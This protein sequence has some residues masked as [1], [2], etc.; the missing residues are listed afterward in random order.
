MNYK[1]PRKAI[2]TDAGFAS[3]YLPITKTIPKGMVP[4]GNKPVM[5]FVVEEC[6]KSGIEEVIIVATPEGKPIY[7]DYFTNKVP[8]I[9]AQL[10]KQGKMDRFEPVKE[11]FN[12]PK[13]TVIEQD[14]S[15]PYGNGSPFASAKSFIDDDEAFLAIYSDDLV[16]GT[17]AVKDLMDSFIKHPDA[18]AIIAGQIVPHE[19]I[20]KY[21]AID[22][23]P[24]T[25][26][27]NGLVEKPAPEEA[28]SDLAS[29]GRYL[30]TP[31]IF[32]FLDPSRTGKD[33]ELWTADAIAALIPTGRVYVKETTGKWVTTGDPKNYFLAHLEYVLKN[34]DYADDVRK[35]VAEN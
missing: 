17:P 29:Y 22:F 9:E 15:Y 3:R 18:V 27:L 14:P 4:M 20:K 25:E 30:L 34:T 16:L 21:A 6:A 28:A 23:N 11:I 13:V 24:E 31:E 33:G 8:K 10:S 32:K 1:L 5:Q 19:E 2:I 12:L 7:E 35:F 26:V